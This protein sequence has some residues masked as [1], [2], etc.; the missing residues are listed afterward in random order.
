MSKEA[1][2]ELDKTLDQIFEENQAKLPESERVPLKGQT[3]SVQADGFTCTRAPH[4]VG[5]HVAHGRL[6][7]IIKRWPQG[8]VA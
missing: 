8:G 2:D 3:C 6:G 7:V 4:G 5:D 1:L